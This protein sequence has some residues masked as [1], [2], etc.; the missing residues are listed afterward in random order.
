MYKHNSVLWFV[1][2]TVSLSFATYFLPLPAESW[3]LLV[4]VLLVFVPTLVCI[5]L[6]LITEGR[7]GLRQL[8]STAS[9][10]VKWLVI[11]AVVGALLRVAVLVTGI[12]LGMPIRA[13]FS[14]PGTGFILLG[15][16]P[17]A[18]LE[19]LGWRRFALDRLLKSRTPLEAALLI[20]L[21]W[22]LLH[23]VILLPGMM[24]AGVP[25]L[26]QVGTVFLMSIFLT[27][28]YVRSGGSVLTVTLLHG[29]QNGMVVLNG[30]IPIVNAAWLMLGVYF[31]IAILFIYLE[32]RLFFSKVAGAEYSVTSSQ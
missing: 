29:V 3:G 30:G 23:I 24:S 6:A 27:W 11:G 1:L 17:L 16:I 9:G 25:I 7:D 8:F 4:P 2:I 26:G 22:G 21:P 32:R 20:G 13:D 18:Y 5:P 31:V 15:T 14:A 10:G 19:E 12:I 28:A